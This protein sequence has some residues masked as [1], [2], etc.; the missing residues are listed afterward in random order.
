MDKGSSV[1]DEFPSTPFRLFFWRNK[2][3]WGTSRRDF[4][5]IEIGNKI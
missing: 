4:N 3:E 5:G 2:V 1:V